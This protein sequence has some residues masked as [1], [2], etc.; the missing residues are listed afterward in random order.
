M[1]QQMLNTMVE[2]EV[3]LGE[4]ALNLARVKQLAVGDTLPFFTQP[5]QPMTVQ[6]GGIP[7]AMAHA[8]QRRQHVAVSLATKIGRGVYS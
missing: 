4:T 2:V 6:C 1:H 3:I 8:G 7:L 5:D